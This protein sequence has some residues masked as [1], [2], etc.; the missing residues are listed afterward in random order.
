[1]TTLS[2][3]IRVCTERS[4]HQ[5]ASVGVFVGAGSRHEDLET[6]GTAYLLE[7]MLLRGTPSR[8]KSEINLAVDSMGARFHSQ[9]G[10]ENSSLQMQV[11]NGDVGKAVKLLGDL[12]SNSNLNANELEVVKQEVSEEHEDNHNRYFETTVENAHFNIYREHMMGQPVKG[13][14]DIT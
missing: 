1:M 12:V 6:S 4:S 10:R 14:R 3:G 2:N 5:T 7:K 8:T 9:T 13:D 11:F